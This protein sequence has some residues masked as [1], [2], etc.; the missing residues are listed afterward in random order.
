MNKE[1]IN[2]RLRE[3]RRLTSNASTR[4]YEKTKNGFL[5]RLYRN[6]KSRITGVQSLKHYLYANKE[7]LGKDEFYLWA[8][9]S[10]EFHR[11]FDEWERLG[12]PR[13][14][15]PSVDRIDTS[16]GYIQGNMQWLTHSQNSSRVP[17]GKLLKN[18][19][20]SVGVK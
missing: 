18:R 7:L 6:M 2:K 14:L 16:L 12:Y 20:S 4:K 8:K 3:R 15:T 17:R 10:S 19:G 9:S 1:M 11:L 13:R 5:M